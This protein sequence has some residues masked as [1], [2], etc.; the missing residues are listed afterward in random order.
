MIK[1]VVTIFMILIGFI[2]LN[3]AEAEENA[4]LTYGVAV[5][6]LS[7]KLSQNVTEEMEIVVLDFTNSEE[8][9]DMFGKFLT[10]ELTAKLSQKEKFTVMEKTGFISV[11]KERN[12]TLEDLTN[13]S[14]MIKTGFLIGVDAICTGTVIDLGDQLKVSVKLINTF[15][16]EIVATAESF[17]KKDEAV[18][19]I[20][21]IKKG[22]E[23]S[24][25]TSTFIQPED[26][27]G[28]K[29]V[30][31]AT[32]L[33]SVIPEGEKKRVTV[34]SFIN[35]DGKVDKFGEH[36]ADE[37][38]SKLH[39]TGKFILVERK[40]LNEVLKEQNL[41][42]STIIDSATA[43]RLG[44][45]LG[46][47]A[48][49]TGTIVDLDKYLRINA[50]LISTETGSILATADTKI[51]KESISS[52]KEVTSEKDKKIVLPK[53][54][55]EGLRGEYFNLPPFKDNPGALSDEP[56]T[57]R[58]DSSID[59]NWEEEY[60]APNISADYFGVRWE[61]MLYAPVTGTYLFRIDHNDG[62]KLAIDNKV[63]IDCWHPYD[64]RSINHEANLFLEGGCWHQIKIEFFEITGR[65]W[66]KLLW[67]QPGTDN[68]EAITSSYLKTDGER[69]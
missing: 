18:L 27:L 2:P 26:Y 16:G 5:E 41:G 17:I 53:K 21:G 61:G 24:T 65:S 48:I 68:L 66:V 40:F 63:A 10:E 4:N 12:L 13:P 32:Q 57:V 67:R 44:K 34:I 50:R 69:R 23:P 7:E 6:R 42:L 59:F 19:S 11:L 49:I 46:V 62:V 35:S 14:S 60:P 64:W 51:A 15:A 36:L 37:L 8:K 31:M 58:I 56:T 54:D 52:P 45:V 47:E 25:K 9:V 3:F 43:I 20:M 30:Q 22:I 39:Q 33:S 38:I 55:R 28:M 29:I 1:K